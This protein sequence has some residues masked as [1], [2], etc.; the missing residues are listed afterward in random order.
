MAN[1]ELHIKEGGMRVGQM[2]MVKRERLERY[3]FTRSELDV[4][5]D[6]LVVEGIDD[7]VDYGDIAT[8]KILRTGVETVLPLSDL[9][10]V[11]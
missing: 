2:V 10:K 9:E 11:R 6:I 3:F 7:D 4:V 5:N 8:V 1:G